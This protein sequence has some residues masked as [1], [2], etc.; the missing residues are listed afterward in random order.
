MQDAITG[1]DNHTIIF[2]LCGWFNW[3]GAA[4]P[5]AKVGNAYRLATDCVGYEQMLL[6]IDALAPV[7]R[8]LGNGFYPDMDMISSQ[9]SKGLDNVRPL[10]G[11]VQKRL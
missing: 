8:F 6:N 2:N 10:P 4:G 7:T 1:L 3:Y 9:A 11:V 5:A